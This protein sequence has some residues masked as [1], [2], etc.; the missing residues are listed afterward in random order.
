MAQ[1]A[2]I[3]ER[4]RA[5]EDGEAIKR[6]KYKYVRCL[7]SKDWKGMAECFTRDATTDYADGKYQY[8]GVDAIIEFLRENLGS[9]GRVT[10]H[11]LHQPEI[12]ITS[13]TTARGTW[14]MSDYVIDKASNVFLRGAAFY[15]DEY[16]KEQ[17]VWKI[18]STGYRRIFEEM[19]SREGLTLTAVKKYES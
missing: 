5:L 13:D 8:R 19:G 6:L 1:M 2:G 14:G 10:V 7:D 12:D 11:Q 4:L 9:H 17:G 18:K 15:H 3:E 16:V